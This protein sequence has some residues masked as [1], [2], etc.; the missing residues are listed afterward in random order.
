MTG[1]RA[2]KPERAQHLPLA[3]RRELV[4]DAALRPVPA[5]VVG[6]LHVAGAGLAGGALGEPE[7][8]AQR[9]VAEPGTSGGERMW[10]SGLAAR[11]G[12]AGSVEIVGPAPEGA[13][14][15]EESTFL[16][17]RNERGEH[18]LWPAQHAAPGGWRSCGGEDLREACLEHIAGHWRPTDPSRQRKEN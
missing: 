13:F 12:P 17:L 6:D 9:F 11:S 4:L 7:E 5:G 10:R 2:D 8:T 16:V 18:C 15:D 1:A 14:E 3:V